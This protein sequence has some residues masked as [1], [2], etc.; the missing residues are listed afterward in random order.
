MHFD[1]GDVFRLGSLIAV[2]LSTG[3]GLFTGPSRS[4]A[5]SW[6]APGV[7]HSADHFEMSL[8]QNGETISGVMCRADNT[9][10]AY[11]DITVVGEYPHVTFTVGTQ[12]FAGKFEDDRDQIAGNFGARLGGPQTA[13]R[14]VRSDTGHCEAARPFP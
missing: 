13:L 10:V 14:F 2:T 5:G 1:I 6:S 11:R 12:S 9:F 8:T 3:C 7:G 4:V